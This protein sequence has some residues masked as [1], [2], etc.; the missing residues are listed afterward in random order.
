MTQ[1]SRSR[2]FDIRLVWAHKQKGAEPL[3]LIRFVLLA[4][5]VAPLQPSLADG[6]E[7]FGPD[8]ISTYSNIPEFA[9]ADGVIWCEPIP[10]CEHWS[11]AGTAS[12]NVDE[13]AGLG[14]LKEGKNKKGFLGSVFIVVVANTEAPLAPEDEAFLIAV[15]DSLRGDNVELTGA[16]FIPPGPETDELRKWVFSLCPNCQ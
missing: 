8:L 3:F 14:P 9:R 12:D 10:E 1:T 7:E 4:F 16:A 11:K 15:A 13:L 2:W 5:L 6:K